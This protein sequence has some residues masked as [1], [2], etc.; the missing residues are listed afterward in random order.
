MS[1]HPAAASPACAAHCLVAA[2]PS[3]SLDRR[4]FVGRSLLT[5][6]AA[7]LG[8][9]LLA[10]CAGGGADAVA[11]PVA[12][13]TTLR[14][15]DYPALAAVGGIATT[16]AGGQPIAVVR[17]AASSYVVLSR[18]CPHQGATVGVSGSGFR[19]PQHGATFAADGSWTGGERTSGLRAYA[20]TY[21]AAAGTITVG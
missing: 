13:G 15:A 4:A 5:A 17:T 11:G 21:D 2:A 8:A 9:D 3:P 1:D 18:V 16:T 6:A 10:A 12:S 14:V 20:T 19:C 7:A